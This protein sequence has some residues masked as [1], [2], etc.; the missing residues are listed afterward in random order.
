MAIK[1]FAKNLDEDDAVNKQYQALTHCLLHPSSPW[2]LCKAVGDGLDQNLL[3]GVVFN[4]FVINTSGFTPI[5]SSGSMK[6]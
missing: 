1:L 5:T 6:S 2:D 3:E 4:P